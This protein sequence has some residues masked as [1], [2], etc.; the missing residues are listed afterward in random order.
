MSVEVIKVTADPSDSQV[1]TVRNACFAFV[2][3]T[4]IKEVGSCES[5][6]FAEKICF[7]PVVC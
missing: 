5:C 2:R 1:L 7:E 4:Q 6:G 3:M